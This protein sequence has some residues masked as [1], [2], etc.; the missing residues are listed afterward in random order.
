MVEVHAAD[1]AHSHHGFTVA[2]TGRRS[3]YLDKLA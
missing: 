3:G 1:H 2:P